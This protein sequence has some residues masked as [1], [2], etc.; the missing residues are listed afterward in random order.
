MS[1]EHPAALDNTVYTKDDQAR[2]ID[3]EWEEAFPSGDC[4]RTDGPA[5]TCHQDLIPS[6]MLLQRMTDFYPVCRVI[7]THAQTMPRTR[8]A[9]STRPC[10]APRAALWC[11]RLAYLRHCLTSSAAHHPSNSVAL[12][13]HRNDDDNG[14]RRREQPPSLAGASIGPRRPVRHAARPS[15]SS[16]SSKVLVL[17]RRQRTTAHSAAWP[18]DCLF[19]STRLLLAYRCLSAVSGCPQSW[20]GRQPPVTA[21][22]RPPRLTRRLLKYFTAALAASCCRQH[23]QHEHSAAMALS[24]ALFS[25]LA[26]AGHAAQVP[27][28]AQPND[29]G[30][31]ARV[32]AADVAKLKGRFLHITGM[33]SERSRYSKARTDNHAR[34]TSR[35]L[36]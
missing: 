4:E 35:S 31:P 12:R 21:S 25:L 6:T 19:Y 9:D 2:G 33:Q 29:H 32:P 10:S 11:T 16:S 5:W 8:T 26:V 7:D 22:R 30:L 24:V 27:L 28:V 3:T 17:T 36:L 18:R 20:C 34:H 15:R 1:E 13:R 14:A 23:L